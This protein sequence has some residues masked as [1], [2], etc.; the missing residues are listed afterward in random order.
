M[1]ASARR[2]PGTRPEYKPLCMGGALQGYA[3]LR[4]GGMRFV[5][6]V[7][8][9]WSWAEIEGRGGWLGGRFQRA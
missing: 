9:V 6:G 7:V 5:G 1:Q 4:I 8:R 3:A 2:G